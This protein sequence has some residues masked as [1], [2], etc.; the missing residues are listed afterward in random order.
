[1]YKSIVIVAALAI[2]PT[3][4]SSAF[5]ECLKTST[6]EARDPRAQRDPDER[7][8]AKAQKSL[9][10]AEKKL[11]VDQPVDQPYIAKKLDRLAFLCHG[12]GDYEAAR[13]LWE[14]ALAIREKAYGPNHPALSSNL[15]R[16]ATLHEEQSHYAQAEDL[17]S[18]LLAVNEA[19]HGAQHPRTIVVLKRLAGVYRSQGRLAHAEDAYRT[20]L[21]YYEKTS[22]AEHE[23][24]AFAIN[25][26]ADTYLYEGRFALAES[27]YQKSLWIRT[28]NRP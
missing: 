17:W 8:L 2:C 9:E 16:L 10:A 13:V 15:R 19:T 14:R 1:M 23:H 25:D 24:V 21:A 20:V 11:G 28:V 5:A 4:A 22:G 6:G 27:L 18:R 7:S 26:L 12:R 3:I